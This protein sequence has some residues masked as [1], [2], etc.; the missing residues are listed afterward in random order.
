MRHGSYV[1][2]IQKGAKGR[3]AILDLK[4]SGSWDCV[5]FAVDCQ[6][7]PSGNNG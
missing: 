4:Q 7:L 3:V 5:V 1:E 2:L 6:T